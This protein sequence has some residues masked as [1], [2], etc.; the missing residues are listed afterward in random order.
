[1]LPTGIHVESYGTEARILRT[2]RSRVWALALL[3]VLFVLPW[4]ASPYL[5]GIA[6]D[7]LITLVAVYG[8]YV[9]VGMAGQINV[10]QSAFVGIGAFATA[11][12]SGIGVSFLL[13]IP[14]AALITASVSVLFAFTA[15]RLKGFYLALTT[16]AAQVM[17][18]IVILALPEEWMGG[19]VGMSVE[20]PGIGGV[21]L[22][23]PVGLYG[24]VLTVALVTTFAAFNLQRSR[25][26]RA[27]MAVRDN[28][29]VAEV[30]GIPVVRIKLT[31]FFAG[32]LFAGAA[33]ACT[34]YFLQF[35]TVSSFTLFASIWYLGMLIVGGVQSPLGAILGVV[36]IT[37]VQ[38]GLHAVAN[39]AM[40]SGSGGA[41]TLFALTSIA[42][43]AFILVALI[44][45]PRG[46][47]HRW[48]VLRTA[49]Q[50]WPFPR[51]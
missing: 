47:A 4:L 28:D 25:V 42:L 3:A 49:F 15:A 36:F 19:L 10:A 32:S 46:L 14:L 44:F 20:P 6:T 17:F 51:N 38:E 9:T 1:M 43:G 41:G 7:M 12:L 8:L 22:G 39:A 23:T 37:L 26:G 13:A 16:L 2:R 40:Q 5:L 24:L 27:M 34:A 21:S 33:G 30:M 11:K 29:I 48:A 31:A 45:E 35:V 50:L 18:P